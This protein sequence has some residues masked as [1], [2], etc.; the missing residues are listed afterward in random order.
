MDS[1]DERLKRC[2]ALLQHAQQTGCNDPDCEIHC[3][4]MQEDDAE[5]T[6]ALAFYVAGAIGYAKHVDQYLE[7]LQQN[8]RDEQLAPE[9]P[10]EYAERNLGMETTE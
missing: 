7:E 5:R 10:G 6:L 1:Y 8:I 4:W 3:P 2:Q 9:H